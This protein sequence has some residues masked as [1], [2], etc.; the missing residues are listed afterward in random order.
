MADTDIPLEIENQRLLAEGLANG[1]A[2]TLGELVGQ[3]SSYD[4]K[5]LQDQ[6]SVAV[7]PPDTTLTDIPDYQEI[8]SPFASDVPPTPGVLANAVLEDFPPEPANTVGTQPAFVLPPVPSAMGSFQGGAAPTIDT[9][10]PTLTVSDIDALLARIQ[11]VA[12]IPLNIPTRPTVTLPEYVDSDP[13]AA[14][15]APTG[16]D[17]ELNEAYQSALN[18][19]NNSITANCDAWFTRFFPNHANQVA[20]LEARLDAYLAG[21]TAVSTDAASAIYEI[22]RGKRDAEYHRV[23]RSALLDAGKRGFVLPDGVLHSAQINARSAAADAN[24]QAAADIRKMLFD[25]E[26]KNVQFAVTESRAWRSVA[27]QSY[28]GM[29]NG[30]ATINGQAIE[31][32]NDVVRSLVDI[33]NAQVS[34]YN[35]RQEGRR[36]NAFVYGEKVKAA[37]SVLDVYKSE[38]EGERLKMDMNEA[39]LRYLQTRINIIEAY[40]N[41]FRA[42][43]EMARLKNEIE[44]LKLDLYKAKVEAYAAEVG[45]KEA[46]SRVFTA[47]VEGQKALQ[48]AWAEQLRARHAELLGWKTEIQA[49]TAKLK[50]T[51]GYNESITRQFEAATR[52]YEVKV[53]A[54]TAIVDAHVA[55][56]RAKIEGIVAGNRDI[57]SIAELDLKKWEVSKELVLKQS[58]LNLNRAKLEAEVKIQNLR[59][60]FDVAHG[61]SEQ[62]SRIAQAALSGIN[63]LLAQTSTQSS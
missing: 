1:A 42:E 51:L 45:A 5:F 12:L 13:G 19:A 39:S 15:V 16:L 61:I 56:Y 25:M 18:V 27:I 2:N 46:E 50:S 59:L 32:A 6:A 47:Q 21:G 14:P 31:Y 11:D 35:V 23:E 34:A 37:L 60:Q 3:T 63:T 55:Q 54:D 40:V 9:T 20:A 62:F 26:Q 53:R 7:V 24:A 29:F 52:A 44:R 41:V 8:P 33:F 17:D 38:L 36:I 4:P 28:Q 49:I 43:V 10:T 57:A 58:D 30:F 22:E 48:A